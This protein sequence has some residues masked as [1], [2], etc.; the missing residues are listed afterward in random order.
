MSSKNPR[1]DPT[2]RDRFRGILDEA[3]PEVMRVV[4]E[5]GMLRQQYGHP[6]GRQSRI[7]LTKILPWKDNPFQPYSEQQLYELAESIEKHGL[8]EP[9]VLRQR[10]TDEGVEYDTLSGHNR[11]AA[12]RLLGRFDIPSL[13]YTMAD[14]PD[15]LA[16]IFVTQTNLLK[17]E[18]LLPS[19]KA[20]AY[21]IMREAQESRKEQDKSKLVNED[22]EIVADKSDVPRD[23]LD[24][25]SLLIKESRRQVI[26]YIRLNE[27]I[28][29]LLDM[30]DG[31]NVPLY[32]G[33]ALSYVSSSSQTAILEYLHTHSI[34]RVTVLQAEDLRQAS[35]DGYKELTPDAIHE[36]FGSN[37][38]AMPTDDDREDTD[39]DSSSIVA[40][41]AERQ[42]RV[43]KPLKQQSLS[44]Y[45][46]TLRK[47]KVIAHS[48]R[49][50]IE[51]LVAAAAIKAENDTIRDYMRATGKLT[52]EIEAY[53][54]SRE[55]GL[56][57]FT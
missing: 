52:P 7:E 40:S 44:S 1:F 3:P 26:R 37:P 51:S 32:A 30:V 45:L 33:V 31:G 13:V 11:V 23:V 28:P 55:S 14:M 19:E 39:L 20:K 17:R 29:A 54:A 36:V 4:E 9:V 6:M 53:L 50:R 10:Q 21:L 5:V 47:E 57:D 18:R 35:G 8:M 34:S 2:N 48:E 46:R 56:E 15:D 49:I 38:T 24:E 43:E 41:H 12:F 16:A 27:L 22:G 42:V 25:I